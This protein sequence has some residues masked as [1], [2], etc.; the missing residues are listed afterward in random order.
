MSATTVWIVMEG[1]P[2]EGGSVIGVFA[3]KELAD[4]FVLK[5]TE[6]RHEELSYMW[7]TVK[8]YTVITTP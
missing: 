4:E 1:E 7:T 3:T 6:D 2:Y 8:E 5:H